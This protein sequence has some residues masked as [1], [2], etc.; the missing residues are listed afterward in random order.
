[1]D[2]PADSPVRDYLAIA[3]SDVKRLTDLVSQLRQVYQPGRS[4]KKQPVGLQEVL[5]SVYQLVDS[6]FK[7]N[8]V[9]WKQKEVPGDLM[10]YG[11][12][13]QLIQVCLN[14]SLNALEAMQPR[15]GDFF[16][17]W[18]VSPDGTQV[19][20]AFRDTGRGIPSG[21]IEKLFDPYFTT[22]ETGIGL[23]LTTC[24]EIITQHE[25]KTEVESQPGVGTTVTIWLPQPGVV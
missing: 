4:T 22:K 19:G 13:S 15:G 21:D 23:G 10:V 2:V 17:T 18:Q 24:K 6:Q 8:N 14:I 12:P 1:M 11:I 5:E 25:G 20:V 3:N 16:I 7:Q 9:N